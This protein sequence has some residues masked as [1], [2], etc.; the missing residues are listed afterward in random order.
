MNAIY[1]ANGMKTLAYGN[2]DIE[3]IK[4]EL[5]NQVI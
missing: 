2:E 5:N 4:S 1:L 3:G